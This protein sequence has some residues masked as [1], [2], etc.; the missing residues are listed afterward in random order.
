[1]FSQRHQHLHRRLKLSAI[2]TAVLILAGAPV[3][4]ALV[5]SAA[6]HHEVLSTVADDLLETQRASI[7]A[8][9]RASA[10][11]SF[12]RTGDP[13]SLADRVT[14]DRELAAALSQLHKRDRVLAGVAS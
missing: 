6:R 8:T 9:S 10:V 14:A 12:I 3:L 4:L 1:M 11:R 7:A 5:G 13:A 2:V